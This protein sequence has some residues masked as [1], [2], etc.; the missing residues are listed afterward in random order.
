MICV[1]TANLSFAAPIESK[2]SFQ[3]QP[4]HEE[5]LNNVLLT[6]VLL[7]SKLQLYEI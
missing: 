6:L 2:R 1:H 7:Y 5:I 3:K 4:Y